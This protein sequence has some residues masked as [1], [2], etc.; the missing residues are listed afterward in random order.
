MQW[1]CCLEYHQAEVAAARSALAPFENVLDAHLVLTHS[2]TQD[3]VSSWQYLDNGWS[4]PGVLFGARHQSLQL[5]AGTTNRWE[6]EENAT[7][8]FTHS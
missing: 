1:S 3:G 6:L 2:D 7:V 8:S 5:G 4:S